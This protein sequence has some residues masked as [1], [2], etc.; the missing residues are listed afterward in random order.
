[1]QPVLHLVPQRGAAERP[2]HPLIHLRFVQR[3][4]QLHPEGYVFEN[5]HRKRRRLLEH[6]ADPAAQ[7]IQVHPGIDDVLSVHHHL[8]GCALSGVQVIHP[9]QHPQ[10]RRF[11]AAGRPDH[12]G[13]LTIRQFQVDPLQRLVRSVEEIQARDGNPR[14]VQC[15]AGFRLH[16]AKPGTGLCLVSCRAH[17]CGSAVEFSRA[18]AG[19]RARGC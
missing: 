10:Q 16:G 1:M 8:A 17:R 2:F 11:A 9:V 19:Q 5:R 3:L 4:M 12:T 13:H 6:H 18:A 15:L 14:C 7:R